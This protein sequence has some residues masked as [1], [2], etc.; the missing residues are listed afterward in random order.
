MTRIVAILGAGETGARWKQD[1]LTAGWQVRIFDPDPEAPGFIDMKGDCRRVGTISGSV[2]EADWIVVAVPDRLELMQKIIQRAQAVAPPE[3]V[4]AAT[5][6]GHDIDALQGCGLRAGNIIR[7]L[8][9]ADGGFDLHVTHRN[10]DGF[11]REAVLAL[12][13]LS[14]VRCLGVPDRVEPDQD[15]AA[16]A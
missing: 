14:A 7:V 16:S 8:R 11:R 4:I 12:S 9:D 1:F 15:D 3:A 13:E 10:D 2:G 5:S 6:R